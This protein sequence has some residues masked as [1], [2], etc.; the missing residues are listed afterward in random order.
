MLLFERERTGKRT[1]ERQMIF[2]C[3]FIRFMKTMQKRTSFLGKNTILVLVVIGCLFSVPSLCCAQHVTA[4]IKNVRGD[5]LV[6]MPG[7]MPAK[8]GKVLQAGDKILTLTGA[9]VVLK[10]TDGTRLEL[11]ENTNIDMAEL[12][13]Q[14][15][16]G[17][18]ISRVKLFCGQLRASLSSEHRRRGA[19]FRIETPN[20][21]IAVNLSQPDVEVAYDPD[22]NVTTVFTY[23]LEVM[24]A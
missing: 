15:E 3:I 22:M 10:L 8:V 13:Y 19:S 12:K 2:G 18:R 11:N 6:I 7:T 20:A 16:T 4:T 14:P 21:T 5:A 9:N 23:P 24:T 1:K 17:A